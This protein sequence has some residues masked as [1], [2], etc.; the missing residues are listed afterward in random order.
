MGGIAGGGVSLGTLSI[1]IEA[2]VDEAT[3]ALQDFDAET[4]R[5]VEN[6]K[7]KWSSLGDIGSSLTSVGVGLSA[8]ISRAAPARQRGGG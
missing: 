3:R 5:I 1:A 8:A 4:G 6:Q 7:S 2:T